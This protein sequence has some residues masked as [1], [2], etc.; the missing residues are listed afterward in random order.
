MLNTRIPNLKSVLL[1]CVFI[2]TVQANVSGKCFQTGFYIGPQIGV[3]FLHTNFV[4]S[5][6]VGENQP[7]AKSS[8][9][10]TIS[11]LYGGTLGYRWI[12]PSNFVLGANLDIDF[13]SKKIRRQSNYREAQL[14]TVK[15]ELDRKV[16]Y[17]PSILFGHIL[18]HNLMI[19]TQL[20]MMIGQY[21]L[22][23]TYPEGPT[24]HKKKKTVTGFIGGL[25]A[26]YALNHKWSVKGS[27]SYQVAQ[28]FRGD[29]KGIL[30]NNANDF[31][32][33]RIT[34]KSAV[35]KLAAI[36]KL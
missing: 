14:D 17:T 12:H 19:F 22:K 18:Q 34:N 13:N 6:R 20:G 28:S 24:H 2:P 31:E 16:T 25:G 36:Y 3:D 4:T 8:D 11:F 33:N 23:S 5:L 21:Q 27:A 29:F 7:L 1:S 10:H 35:I 32:T 30:G 9:K 26:E 15:S